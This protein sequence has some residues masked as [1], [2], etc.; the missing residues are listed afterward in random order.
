MF[1][2]LVFSLAILSFTKAASAEPLREKAQVA[3]RE[4][5][6]PLVQKGDRKAAQESL[7]ACTCVFA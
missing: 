1:K 6:M 3:C 5:L 7:H 2:A 4:A